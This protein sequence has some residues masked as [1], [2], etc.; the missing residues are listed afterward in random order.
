MLSFTIAEIIPTSLWDSH[1]VHYTGN[2]RK[3]F[4]KCDNVASVQE[5]L[6][7]RARTVHVLII[8]ANYGK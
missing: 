6:S 3:I 4:V 2:T 5:I 1:S 8:L 7:G